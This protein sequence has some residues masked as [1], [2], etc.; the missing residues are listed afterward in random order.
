MLEEFTSAIEFASRCGDIRVVV[1]TGKGDF[2]SSGN[3]LSNFLK[4]GDMSQG[5]LEKPKGNLLKFVNV[6][7]ECPKIMIAG[8]NGPAIGMGCTMLCHFDFVYAVKSAYFSTPFTELAQTPELCSSYLFPQR[9]G[10]TKANEMLLLGK[11]LSSSDL[12][13]LLVTEVFDTVPAVLEY[14]SQV[15]KRVSS[16]PPECLLASKRLIVERSIELLKQINKEEVEELGRRWASP[17]L[18]EAVAKFMN[19]KANL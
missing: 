4:G 19:R 10:R 6:L 13:H 14:T 2:F 15:A 16:F 1:V 17:E 8:V 5:A 3:D 7:I 18:I 11:K 12:L 9:L